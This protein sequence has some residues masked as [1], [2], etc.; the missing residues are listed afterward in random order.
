M[1][2]DLPRKPCH[3]NTRQAL[4]LIV[5]KLQ[6]IISCGLGVI[7]WWAIVDFPETC[8]K[9]F[10]FLTQ[11]ESDFI[12]ARINLDRRDVVI[13]PFSWPAYLEGALD[14]KIWGFAALFM[15]SGT[16]SYAASYFLPLMYGP[17]PLLPPFHL[18]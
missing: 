5:A 1:A 18:F 16:T 17:P 12:C 4:F 7:G 8:S 13:E 10:M 2:M 15:L 3:P 9:S 11:K 6:G 14:L